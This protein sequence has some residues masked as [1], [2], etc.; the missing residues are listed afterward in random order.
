MATQQE[1]ISIS[2]DVT[3]RL[4]ALYHSG[5]VSGY[6]YSKLPEGSLKT[7]W[8]EQGL[9]A[10]GMKGQLS[11]K[12][13]QESLVIPADR[14]A[15]LTRDM[16]GSGFTSIS[17]I[18]SKGLTERKFVVMV[19]GKRDSQS[20]IAFQIQKQ[21][22]LEIIRFLLLH[23]LGKN[24]SKVFDEPTLDYVE[25]L[26]MDSKEKLVGDV[27]VLSLPKGK[28]KMSE[29]IKVALQEGALD[30]VV[31]R[32]GTS[33]ELSIF[34][35]LLTRWVNGLKIFREMRSPIA[36]CVFVKKG[37][38]DVCFWDSPQRLAA[39]GTING[40]DIEELSRKYLVPLWTVPGDGILPSTKK[41]EVV[42][43][44]R[45]GTDRRKTTPDNK[46]LHTE[47]MKRN[48]ES[49]TSRLDYLSISSL[50]TRLDTIET[51]VQTNSGPAVH[52][53][54]SL[55]ALQTRLSSTIDR[56]ETLSKRLVELEKRIKKISSSR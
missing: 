54:G 45:L 30:D 24:V 10:K 34:S 51:N 12:H 50:E 21:S 49:L 27:L 44:S 8:I 47:D 37:H 55:D 18:G 36:A 7:G 9:L 6:I 15:R 5:E 11:D 53:K 28:V 43:E 40:V 32:H 52:E 56:I 29:W 33:K 17:V 2:N 13:N 20:L 25:Q 16:S 41:R 23:G 1:V 38:V 35:T 31:F 39:F 42:V 4:Q 26:R 48:I 19:F 14:F 3:I 46:V 22:P